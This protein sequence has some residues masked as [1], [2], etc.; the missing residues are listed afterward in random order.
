M[1]QYVHTHNLFFSFS[2]NV[3]FMAKYADMMNMVCWWSHFDM[4]K[5]QLGYSLFQV[6]RNNI[7]F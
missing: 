7:L 2:A 5:T 4:N 3:P 1:N 6:A